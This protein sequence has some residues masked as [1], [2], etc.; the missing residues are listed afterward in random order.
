M[1]AQDRTP[2]S[3]RSF[4]RSPLRA[5]QWIR[6]EPVAR[7]QEGRKRGFRA[8]G[9]RAF[10]VGPTREWRQR[11]QDRFDSSA[12]LQSEKGPPV[13]DEVELDVAPAAQELKAASPLAERFESVAFHDRHVRLDERIARVVHECVQLVK[14]TGRTVCGALVRLAE[15]VLI[16]IIVED[17]ADPARLTAMS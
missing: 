10:V 3:R 17:A 12:A 14:R 1:Q 5:L 2:S 7:L 4:G 13:V 15:A 9:L 11:H 6:C 8:A 16:E